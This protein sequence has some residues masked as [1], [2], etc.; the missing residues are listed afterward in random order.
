M[1]PALTLAVLVSCWACLEPYFEHVWSLVCGVLAFTL[2]VLGSVGLQTLSLFTVLAITFA[3]SG[4]CRHA[5]YV[6]IL[7]LALTFAGSWRCRHAD[8]V[9]L[10]GTRTYFYWLWA[11]LVCRFCYCLQCSHS[12]LLVR[13]NVGMQILSL[14]TSVALAFAGA[15][16]CR[17]ADF[18]AIHGAHAH[19]CW[20]WAV[21]LPQ[22]RHANFVA[23]YG[24]RAH[25]CWCWAVYADFETI[26][27]ARA[28]FSWF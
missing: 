14:S 10:Y 11:T 18:V 3:G 15:G 16:Q 25:F 1:V 28:H 9:A 20:V 13:G 19:C 2:L 26:W 22:C 5:D 12:L 21:A 27:S 4:Q 8:V 6:A 23:I 24:A 7:V 17:H